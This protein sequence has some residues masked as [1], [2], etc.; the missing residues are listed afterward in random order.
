MSFNI[1]NALATV[2]LSAVLLTP[3]LIMQSQ[4]QVS[5][6]AP[7]GVAIEPGK[8]V[9]NADKTATGYF[10]IV[11]DP[12]CT[13]PVSVVS[14]H[15]DPSLQPKPEFFTTQKMYDVKTQTFGVGSHSMTVKLPVCST[16]PNIVSGYQ[17]DVFA[18]GNPSPV[19]HVPNTGGFYDQPQAAGWPMVIDW[20]VGGNK[21]PAPVAPPVVTPQ[22]PAVATPVAS[23]TVL[24]NAGAGSVI[25]ITGAVTALAAAGHNLVMRRRNS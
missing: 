6:A 7:C 3:L 23:P 8:F 25:G 16:D 22:A 15:A 5:A 2:S 12:G 9:I 21:C 1:R 14:W 10:K 18:T 4:D 17:V 24:P 19:M 11:G 20:H 13:Y